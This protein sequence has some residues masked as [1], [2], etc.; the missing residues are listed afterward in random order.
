M[1]SAQASLKSASPAYEPNASDGS[2]VS[3]ADD[4]PSRDVHTPPPIAPVTSHNTPHSHKQSGTVPHM[5]SDINHEARLTALAEEVRGHVVGPMPVKEF[6]ELYVPKANVPMQ[7]FV[8]K[9]ADVFEKNMKAKETEAPMI[10]E[11]VCSV[12]L[13]YHQL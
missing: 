6:L 7:E 10:E 11:W 5:S 2:V 3:V 9:D 1:P 12:Y 8:Q 13:S 4:T